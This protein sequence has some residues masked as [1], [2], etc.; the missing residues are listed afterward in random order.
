MSSLD[1]DYQYIKDIYDCS[2]ILMSAKITFFYENKK[3]LSSLFA[4]RHNMYIASSK[5]FFK[6]K[7]PVGDINHFDVEIKTFKYKIHLSYGKE[8][9]YRN[10]IDFMS[11]ADCINFRIFL[12]MLN[13]VCAERVELDKKNN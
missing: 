8:N 4:T 1:K 11:K 13:E 3:I 7:I 10:T 5:Y 9:E 2:T 6:Y 12:S